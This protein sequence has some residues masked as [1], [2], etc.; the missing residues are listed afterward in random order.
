MHKLKIIDCILPPSMTKMQYEN[1][2]DKIFDEVRNQKK[3]VII[4]GDINEKSPKWRSP[5]ADKRGEYWV[6]CMAAADVSICND[7]TPTFVRG[8]SKTHI[9]VTCATSKIYQK[10]KHWTTLDDEIASHHRPITF[11]V[12]IKVDRPN[13][14]LKKILNSK[15]SCKMR[16]IGGQRKMGNPCAQLRKNSQRID[17][18][19][20][21]QQTN[22]VLV[23]Y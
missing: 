6:E 2:V 15:Q 14:G 1:T 16:K 10:I 5:N 22:A 3:E 4:L 13:T 23:E 21:K 11:S 20:N 7:G 18:V 19:H 8:E 9:D 12:E 17:H